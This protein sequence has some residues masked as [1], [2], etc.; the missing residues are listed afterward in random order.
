MISI[1]LISEEEI[2]RS[3]L[4]HLLS[5]EADLSVV[6]VHS[7]RSA[8]R[9]IDKHKPDVVLVH[10]PG[11]MKPFEQF[12]SSTLSSEPNTRF[13]IVGRSP[14]DRELQSILRRGAA[15]VVLFTAAPAELFNA[16][17][18]VAA[19]ER[20]I[21][22]SLTKRLISMVLREEPPHTERLSSREQQVLRLIAYGHT[23]K[24]IAAA[25]SIS[26]KSVETYLA[27]LREKL[28]LR[29]R[30]EIVRYAL[31]LGLFSDSPHK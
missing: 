15:G 5:S 11:P 4:K 23:V 26:N 28:H 6:G 20:V 24:E 3:A 8:A 16:I 29:T 19:G 31:E 22:P 14:T 9:M 21:D 17:R 27:R 2:P 1:I 13:L 7:M 30:A 12:V 10:V 25:L 18:S